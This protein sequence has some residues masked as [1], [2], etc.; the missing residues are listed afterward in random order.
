MND[1]TLVLED[2]GQ[3]RNADV[4]NAKGSRSNDSRFL[5]LGAAMLFAAA[6]LLGAAID[7]RF[8]QLAPPP[9]KVAFAEQGAVVLE[10]MLGQPGMRN[11]DAK[12]IVGDTLRTVLE[13]YQRAGYL[14][15]NVTHSA[16]GQLLV[17]AIPRGALDITAEM[18]AS[19]ARAVA[20]A[21]S[22]PAAGADGRA[23][24]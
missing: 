14:V 8:F 18:R 13:K 4:A 7:H 11:E 1:Q 6:A 15:I 3:Q 5:V 17:S 21:A 20:R 19:V 10:A 24:P 9:P 22:N 2:G 23:N 12:S 16:D